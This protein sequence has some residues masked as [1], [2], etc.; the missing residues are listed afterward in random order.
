MAGPRDFKLGA[1]WIILCAVCGLGMTL[2]SL[3][4]TTVSRLEGAVVTLQQQQVGNDVD[5]KRLEQLIIQR[6]ES[7]SALNDEQHKAILEKLDR[8]EARP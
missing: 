4:Q 7:M 8:L 3:Q 5:S 1:W 2:Y 6:L